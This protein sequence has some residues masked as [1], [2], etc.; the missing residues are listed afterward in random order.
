MSEAA[1]KP[2]EDKK[3]RVLAV[4]D[5]ATSLAILVS[6]L[7]DLHYDVLEAQDGREALDIIE[8]ESQNI[9]VIVLDKVMPEM[10]GLEVVDQLKEDPKVQHIPVIMVT[11]ST[12]AEEVKEGIDAGVFYYM[13]KPYEDDVFKSVIT[14]AMR[15]ANRRSSLKQDL[16]KHQTSFGFITRAEFTIRKVQEAEDLACFLA[17]CFPDP[18]R[19][20][21]G[22]ACLLVNAVEHGNLEITYDKKSKLLKEGSLSAEIDRREDMAKYSKRSVHV[23]LERND[24]EIRVI[25]EDEGNGFDWQNYMDIDPAR[26]LETHGR[27]IAQANKISFDEL[28]YNDKGNIVTAVAKTGSGIKW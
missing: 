8:R 15:E 11:G 24:D 3:G 28:H 23:I 10:G 18:D 14:S 5:E 7:E 27:G 4:E 9:D 25:I 20:L 2:V 13:T 1:I 6:L 19:I 26:A 17:N 16:K 21:S 22:L 12:K